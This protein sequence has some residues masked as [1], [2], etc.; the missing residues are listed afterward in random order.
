M[1]SAFVYA[2]CCCVCIC[3]EGCAEAPSGMYPEPQGLG[4]PQHGLQEMANFLGFG[5]PIF[6]EVG[7]TTSPFTLLRVQCSRGPWSFTQQSMR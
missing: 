1:P 5:E 3:A 2:L 4:Q 7:H 6:I